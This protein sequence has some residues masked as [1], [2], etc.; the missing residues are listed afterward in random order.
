MSTW[1]RHKWDGPNG[2]RATSNKGGLAVS[3]EKCGCVREYVVGKATFF[4]G[5]SV[6]HKSPDC[7]EK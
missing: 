1:K 5:D 2:R 4:M 6:Y 7:K 3:C